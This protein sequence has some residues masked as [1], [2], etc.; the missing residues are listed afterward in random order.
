MTKCL[1]L[2]QKKRISINEICKILGPF[3]FEKI[4]GDRVNEMNVKKENEA[5]KKIIEEMSSK[6]KSKTSNK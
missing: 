6:E 1:E 4:E 3:L 5:L 2:E